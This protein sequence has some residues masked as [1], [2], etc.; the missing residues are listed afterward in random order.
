MTSATTAPYAEPRFLA[1]NI[2]RSRVIAYELDAR[3]TAGEKQLESTI[4]AVNRL[5]F[6][7]TVAAMRES[8]R[9]ETTSFLECSEALR[10][11]FQSGGHLPQL[12]GGQSY[13]PPPQMAAWE[14]LVESV[15][16]TESLVPDSPRRPRVDVFEKALCEA[17]DAQQ[18]PVGSLA[19]RLNDGY[20]AHQLIGPWDGDR[21][22]YN[23]HIRRVVDRID[24]WKRSDEKVRTRRGL[25][26][27]DMADNGSLVPAT[28]LDLPM[29]AELSFEHLAATFFELDIDLAGI[30]RDIGLLTVEAF[31]MYGA[32][33]SSH[34]LSNAAI[35][36]G[37]P[38]KRADEAKY[39]MLIAQLSDHRI[40]GHDLEAVAGK[41]ETSTTRDVARQ[42]FHEPARAYFTSTAT[43]PFQPIGSTALKPMVHGLLA[44]SSRF[45]DKRYQARTARN[46]QWV[47]HDDGMLNTNA[48]GTFFNW[49]AKPRAGQL[50]HSALRLGLVMYTASC[51]RA[52]KRLRA[53]ASEV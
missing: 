18:Q 33:L 11:K 5:A 4:R 41:I 51:F 35:R 15:W 8:L 20:L 39:E 53:G 1:V 45:T 13:I 48:S 37:R 31:S 10:K 38:V 49:L 29:L 42:L 23:R 40:R 3:M 47:E 14:Q 25:R 9:S 30:R 22:E 19:K 34:I 36:A 28:P 21:T 52:I 44:Q 24:P 27:E 12:G 6:D 16:Q 43:S 26:I 17:F 32:S 7:L 2:A 50:Y 46:L